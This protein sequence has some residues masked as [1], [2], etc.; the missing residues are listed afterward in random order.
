[1]GIQY[2]RKVTI[3]R[4]SRVMEQKTVSMVTITYIAGKCQHRIWGKCMT[5]WWGWVGVGREFLKADQVERLQQH[6][7]AKIV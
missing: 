5:V 4:V 7:T 6:P 2:A 1:M 3:T